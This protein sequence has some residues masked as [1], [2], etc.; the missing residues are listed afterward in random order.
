MPGD[1]TCGEH[2]TARWALHSVQWTGMVE[3]IAWI[4]QLYPR[5]DHGRLA[6]AIHHR[7]CGTGARK[8]ML[9]PEL[10]SASRHTNLSVCPDLD[11][12]TVTSSTRQD[13]PR[14]RPSARPPAPAQALQGRLNFYPAVHET[15]ILKDVVRAGRIQTPGPL[16]GR[17]HQPCHW[18]QLKPCIGYTKLS[19]A[20]HETA[21]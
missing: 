20:G 12:E 9:C 1:C 8:P 21:I 3:D 14:A 10:P 4:E 7:I 16:L 17:N 5:K 18:T 15:A 2:S 11:E 6:A 19:H 13:P